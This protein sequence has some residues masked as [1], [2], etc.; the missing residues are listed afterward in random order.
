MQLNTPDSS[1]RGPTETSHW[2]IPKMLLSSGYPGA[3]DIDEH[4]RVTR[5]I[6]DS[7]IEVFVNLMQEKELARFTPY[8]REIQQY[9]IQDGRNIEFLSFPIPD[10]YV[11][12]DDQKVFEFSLNLLE[13]LKNNH[14]KIL[15]HCWGGH[16]RTGTII[17]ILIGMLFLYE[18][19]DA[20]NYNYQLKRQ[21]LRAKGRTSHLHPRQSEQVR[22]V[23]QIYKDQQTSA[24]DSPIEQKDFV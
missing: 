12:R 15:I 20:L 17:S 21:R 7:G 22:K 10:Q 6:Y 3:K 13:R 9:A 11:C 23:L 16:G 24:I 14:Q 5:A 2:V 18:A 4:R 1:C 8:E 19:D